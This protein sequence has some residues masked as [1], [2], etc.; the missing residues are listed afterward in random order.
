MN[1]VKLKSQISGK[2]VDEL[3]DYQ[4]QDKTIQYFTIENNRTFYKN[5]NNLDSKQL[6]PNETINPLLLGNEFLFN[7]EK[8]QNNN[9]NY[10]FVFKSNYPSFK[11][12][13]HNYRL[14]SN[15]KEK[16]LP[17]WI[18][19][20]NFNYEMNEIKEEY[21]IEQKQRK[22]INYILKNK[23]NCYELNIGDV[24][25]LGRISLILT[26][27]HLKKTNKKKKEEKNNTKINNKTNNKTNNKIIKDIYQ[28][29]HLKAIK[30]RLNSNKSLLTKNTINSG[31][32]IENNNL[33]N[34]NTDSLKVEI[35][36]KKDE[37][38]NNTSLL[39]KNVQKT[40]ENLNN[41]NLISKEKDDFNEKRL[42]TQDNNDDIMKEKI[43][44]ANGKKGNKNKEK[45]S[46]NN[47]I[48]CRVCYSDEKEDNSP[49]INCCNCSGDV[50]YIHLKC[51]ST[52]LKTKSKLLAL[53]NDI[54]KQ[55]IYNKINC[56]ICKE[57]YPE[58][59]F[60]INK[61]KTYKIFR[62]E[63]S[64]SFVNIL[65][66]NYI[67]FESF[68]LVNQKKVIYLI[69]FD[70][71]NAISIG[72]GQDC[73]VR[74]GDVTVSR[75]HSLLLKTK[76]NKIILKDAGSK[77]GTLILLQ[78][79]KML[80]KNKILSLQIGK[81][82]LNLCICYYN[83][84]CL[85]KIINYI[86]G[87]FCQR[88]SRNNTKNRNK[89][90]NKKN[91]NNVSYNNKSRND[92]LNDSNLNMIQIN[93][94]LFTFDINNLDYNTI[95]TRNIIIEELIDIKYQINQYINNNK[96]N[97]INEYFKEID[98]E[99]LNKKNISLESFNNLNAAQC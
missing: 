27:I 75:L 60:D 32:Y 29:F 33:H 91:E 51:L 43:D 18:S 49:L 35:M 72:R 97:A 66:N 82:Y 9:P 57:K 22:N 48:I 13:Y 10:F 34:F 25:K 37:T 11:L 42:N 93:N 67:M 62:P 2:S 64:Y 1:K 8:Y 81:M 86:V 87:K 6:D 88:K 16:D 55:I 61:K 26:K 59:I 89:N 84:N 40:Q 63:D 45:N 21:N 47:N 12:S 73:D 36:L 70:K 50:K 92:Y 68:E 56:E 96:N 5:N 90:N 53:S 44:S 74:L 41:E 52:W 95:N 30:H 76:D 3:F 4:T 7:I 98:V 20:Y 31:E 78:A 39:D 24:I 69:S 71:K 17:A 77:F 83:Y 28:E 38:K 79:K 19:L 58:I 99:K 15:I 54:C 85:Y 94:Y 14:N 46:S 80:I 23:K 65:Y